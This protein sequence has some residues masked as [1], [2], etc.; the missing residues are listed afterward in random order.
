MKTSELRAE[1]ARRAEL[2]QEARSAVAGWSD[3]PRVV[4]VL[5]E[6]DTDN[7]RWL[8]EVVTESGWPQISEVGEEAASNAWLLAQHADLQPEHQR[9]FHQG[10]EA[11]MAAGEAVP[12]LFA[13]LD[14]L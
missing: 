14:G 12:E 2:D 9:M 1:L 5:Q 4:G 8:L 3:D 10:M 13:Y 11:A 7:T 6:V